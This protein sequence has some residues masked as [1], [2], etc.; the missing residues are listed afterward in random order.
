M[1][2]RLAEKFYLTKGEKS[3]LLGYAVIVIAAAV[4]AVV[5]MAGLQAPY[6]LALEASSFLY[7][8]AIA[9]AISGGVSLYFANGWMGNAGMLGIARA[10]VGSVAITVMASVLAG[11]LTVPFD[12]TLYGPLVVL[13][14]FIA[15][16]WIAA[17]WFAATFGAHYLMSTLEEERAFGIGRE[18]HRSATSQ[19]STLSRAQLYHRD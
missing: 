1:L 6:T 15:T 11:T 5:I 14:A 3:Y 8:V 10:I 19:L 16:P 12:G 17:I 2:M 13:S 18:A 7:W 4:L 9:G